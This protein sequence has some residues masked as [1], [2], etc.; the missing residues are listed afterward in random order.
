[1]FISG[2][3]TATWPCFL[4]L[5]FHNYRTKQ[6]FR[7][8]TESH[9]HEG[10][11]P[12]LDLLYPRG[13]RSREST[14]A[15]ACA[16]ESQALWRFVPGGEPHAAG[17]RPPWTVESPP[18]AVVCWVG[19]RLLDHVLPCMYRIVQVTEIS[20][21]WQAQYKKVLYLRLKVEKQ[22]K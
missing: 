19:N 14:S 3:I 1:M 22:Q 13:E 16:H 21:A 8:M 18:L 4:W 15:A 20:Q 5:P 11:F 17:T 7:F 6:H 12:S 2:G 10:V 9:L